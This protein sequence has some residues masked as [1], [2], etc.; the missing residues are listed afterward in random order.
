MKTPYIKAEIIPIQIEAVGVLC[1]SVE[2]TEKK[3]N[4]ET[5]DYEESSITDWSIGFE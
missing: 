5:S 4:V 2:T 1:G 3:F